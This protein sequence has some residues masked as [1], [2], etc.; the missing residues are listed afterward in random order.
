MPNVPNEPTSERFT[1]TSSE[2]LPIRVVL[3][4]PARVKSLV[5]IIHGFKGFKD[6]G[7]FPFLGEA[8]ALSG[9][10]ACRFDMSRSGV[11]EDPERFDR[12]D[13][14]AEDTYSTQLSD[15]NTVVE[16]LRTDPSLRSLP[17]FLLGH[18]RGG[19]IALL[20]SSSI[21]RLC[22]V[23]TWSS[24]STV[25]RWDEAIK[26]QWRRDGF[27][28]VTNQRTGQVMKVSTRI[29]DDCEANGTHL[30]VLGAVR[31]LRTPLLIVHGASDETVAVDEA[32][33]IA[34]NALQPSLV[35][36]AG[37]SHTFSAIHPLIN[38]PQPLRTATRV[39]LGF[40][41]AYSWL[42]G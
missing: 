39:T 22:G 31:S 11:G 21:D 28:E 26:K 30:D 12:L 2:G 19:A 10:A 38:V 36:I 35:V 27:L 23:I 14:F 4:R 32:R 34:S 37:A 40:L 8:L 5:V 15:L 41:N 9:F 6:W 20:G 18:S 25:D 17:I 29:L 24:I 3:D 42:N 33:E 13:L 16:H 1:L 7:F